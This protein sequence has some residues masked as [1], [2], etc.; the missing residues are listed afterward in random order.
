MTKRYK[1]G[2]NGGWDYLAFDTAAHRLF[3]TRGTHVQIVNPDNGAVIGDIPNTPHVHGVALAYD[4]GRG[5]IT[6][7]NSAIHIFDLKTLQPIGTAR[8]DADDN[9]LL[10][11]PPRHSLRREHE[12]R[13]TLG[14]GRRR[15]HRQS[16]GA[17]QL[18]G[19]PEF[20]VSDNHGTVY[21]NIKNKPA[22]RDR[23]ENA[24]DHSPMGPR[25]L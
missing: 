10:Y 6:A 1:V 23:S 21:A 11:N 19:G 12:R 20:A 4:L 2:G 18:P 24:Q 13:L 5:F 8:A 9:G 14:D 16:R 7:A 17:C 25:P 3:I 15:A 22:G